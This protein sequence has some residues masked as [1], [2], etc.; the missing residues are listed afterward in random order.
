MNSLLPR[1]ENGVPQ[2]QTFQNNGFFY[3][4]LLGLLLGVI[5]TGPHFFDWS[6]FSIFLTIAAVTAVIGFLGWIA[7]AVTGGLSTPS[8]DFP[9]GSE[10]FVGTDYD[11]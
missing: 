10:S 7:W 5:I 9:D 11:E 6:L 2:I 1:D 3:G 8:I 4:S